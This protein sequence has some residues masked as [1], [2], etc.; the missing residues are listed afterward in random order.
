MTYTLAPGVQSFIDFNAGF[1]PVDDTLD[2][3]RASFLQ[4]AR[5]STPPLS[6]GWRIDDL[7]LGHLRLRRYQPTARAP[8]GG[9]PTVLYVHDGGWH[10]GDHGYS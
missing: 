10:S 1:T 3:S 5:A 7:V 6:E 8:A 4:L 2:A 9:W